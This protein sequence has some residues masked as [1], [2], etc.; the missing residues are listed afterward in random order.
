[1]NLT[2]GASS[3]A[4]LLVIMMMVALVMQYIL[5]GALGRSPRMSATFTTEPLVFFKWGAA[6]WMKEHLFLESC[7]NTMIQYNTIN[8]VL[9]LS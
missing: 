7:T 2:S 5:N 1:M 8:K 4:K 3:R 6:A 9:L